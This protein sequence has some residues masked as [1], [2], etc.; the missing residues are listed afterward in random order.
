MTDRELIKRMSCFNTNRLNANLVIC[1]DIDM[2]KLESVQ[3]FLE[4]R[5]TN[6]S[7]Y[8]VDQEI[9]NNFLQ[10]IINGNR[11]TDQMVIND[12]QWDDVKKSNALIILVNS[13]DYML[14][15]LLINKL[16]TYKTIVLVD[17]YD[18][19]MQDI[20]EYIEE[21]LDDVYS[22]IN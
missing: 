8:P 19:K 13:K 18:S 22:D 17:Q 10:Q 1:G 9:L 16:L 3:R 11:Q 20:G 14:Y 21:R 12:V 4:D 2:E 7:T 5:Y 6:V 15:K